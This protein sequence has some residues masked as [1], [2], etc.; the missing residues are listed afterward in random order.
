VPVVI[1]RYD[2][3]AVAE[4][5]RLAAEVSRR[6]RALVATRTISRGHAFTGGDV[7]LREVYLDEA[8]PQVL[9]DPSKALGRI[10]AALLR[11]GSIVTVDHLRSPYVV[12]R[13]ELITIRAIVGSVMLKTM[14]RASA[15]ASVGDVIE[16][17]HPVTRQ[18]LQ[19]RITGR[20]E[21][22]TVGSAA[23]Q[24]GPASPDTQPNSTEP[25]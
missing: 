11:E 23:S 25:S 7:E 20:R 24:A 9:T 22:V 21:A 19:V 13:G 12:R 15:D 4:T 8:S 1:Q 16:V 17:R 5:H 18:R 3:L 6:T 10:A 2:G 14:A